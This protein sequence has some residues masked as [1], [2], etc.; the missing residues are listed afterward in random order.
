M[1]KN[2]L[3]LLFG[4]FL[5]LGAT[6][7]SNAQCTS[8]VI[9]PTC[10]PASGGLCPD[11]LPGATQGTPYT[12]DVTFY[13]P[14]TIVVTSPVN[15]GSVPLKSVFIRNVSGLPFGLTWQANKPSKTYYPSS[16][17]N[18]GCVQI[19][20]TTFVAP[21]RYNLT[22][23]VD[24]VVAAGG[25]L[26]DQSGSQSFSFVMEVLP[27]S[28]SNPVFSL[29]PTYS[30]GGAPLSF[31]SNMTA[32]Y[33]SYV[34]YAWSFGDGTTSTNR[35]ETHSYTANGTYSVTNTTT[36]SQLAITYVEFT[37]NSDFTTCNWIDNPKTK[38]RMNSGSSSTGFTGTTGNKPAKFTGLNW[39]LDGNAVVLFMEDVASVCSNKNATAVVNN[40]TGPG[41]YSF[42]GSNYAISGHV[43]VSKVNPSPFTATETVNA[44]SAPASTTIQSNS[45]SFDLCAGDSMELSV[46][47]GYSYRWYLNDTIEIENS[48]TNVWKI[49]TGGRYRVD[50]A[51]PVSGC[52]FTTPTIT[53][54]LLAG[55]PS[56]LVV[57][58]NGTF[59]SANVTGPYTYQWQIQNNGTWYN[60]PA[61]AGVQSI[62]TPNQTA[63]YRLILSSIDGCSISA[64]KQVTSVSIDET[65]GLA[66]LNVYP[67]P[68]DG[69]FNIFLEVT[70][71]A[72]VQIVLLDLSGRT[73]KSELI[74]NVS[75][76]QTLV[77]D[78]TNVSSG[79]YI[80]NTRVNG[81]DRL[82]RVIIK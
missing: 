80:L 31:S 27:S 9:D 74:K 24:A 69:I 59:L 45:G 42:T 34:E 79:V 5:C 55:V 11:S 4:A 75:G 20:G 47:S 73:L 62:Y 44:Y 71:D 54:N 17:E 52:I 16:G 22:V 61:P 39:V 29:T 64:D 50:I 60:I 40:I 63:N 38:V 23:N 51:D 41:T 2:L 48:D 53:V 67:V 36:I 26:G 49:K 15:L 46:Y 70:Q 10:M 14:P 81:V 58:Y 28:S 18:H 76:T 33:P 56:N 30:C 32:T 13:L 6:L 19:C 21:G 72:D 8:C 25:A 82:N 3:A 68:S 37:S 66:Q 7:E 35:N 43:V 57:N 1:K 12:Q 77:F 65:S 78:A